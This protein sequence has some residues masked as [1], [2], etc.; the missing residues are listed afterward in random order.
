MS[1]RARLEKL[2]EEVHRLGFYGPKFW[3]IEGGLTEGVAEIVT[4]DKRTWQ[5]REGESEEAFGQRMR[6]EIK[7]ARPRP[8]F[9]VVGG[10]PEPTPRALSTPQT[11]E[12]T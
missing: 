1:L 6:A 5:P 12:L 4:F 3:Q 2:K 9:V 8:S 10:L 7:S 11:E